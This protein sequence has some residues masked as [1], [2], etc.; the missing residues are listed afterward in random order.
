MLADL[1][2]FAV[3]ENVQSCTNANTKNHRI[4]EQR[5]YFTEKKTEA[6]REGKFLAYVS[7][8][9]QSAAEEE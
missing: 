8:N 4:L 7:T 2:S 5:T 6:Q 9:S 1:S 3:L